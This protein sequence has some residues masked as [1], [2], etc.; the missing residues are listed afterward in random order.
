MFQ[1]LTF[2]KE[3]RT[4]DIAYNPPMTCHAVQCLHRLLCRNTSLDSVRVTNTVPPAYH[5]ALKV[6][7]GINRHAAVLTHGEYTRLKG[8][9]EEIN[10]SQTGRLQP[11]E[12][13]RWCAA[14]GIPL[15][16]TAVF[17]ADHAVNLRTSVAGPAQ[18]QDMKEAQKLAAALTHADPHVWDGGMLFSELL[19][20]VYPEIG[21]NVIATFVQVCTPLPC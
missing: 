11:E 1:V 3:L 14:S 16:R 5:E 12:L 18:R 20:T 6:R 19:K 17:A 2:H 15:K 7:T 10:I 9:F 4:L 13:V 21:V 8:M